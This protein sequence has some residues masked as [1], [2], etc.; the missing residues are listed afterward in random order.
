M[1]EEDSEGEAIIKNEKST[2]GKNFKI[3]KARKPGAS[4]SEPS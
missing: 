4:D 1:F 2:S 3:K